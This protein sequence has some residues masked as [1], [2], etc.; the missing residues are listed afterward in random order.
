M[1]VEQS[2]WKLGVA[3]LNACVV[4]C[5]AVQYKI[6]WTLFTVFIVVWP[7]F[8]M[9][10]FHWQHN[11]CLFVTQIFTLLFRPFLWHVLDV[12]TFGVTKSC[13]FHTPQVSSSTQQVQNFPSVHTN[14]FI[15]YKMSY[16]MF[17]RFNSRHQ[18]R[19]KNT[20]EKIH[21]WSIYTKGDISTH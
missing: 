18:V 2:V 12:T 6:A 14:C 20:I 5:V 17:R 13:I 1:N 3:P 7:L 4:L 8:M 10:P 19:A 21:S 15:R 11:F 16:N 9:F